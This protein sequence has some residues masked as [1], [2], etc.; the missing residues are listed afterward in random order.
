[1]KRILIALAV[2]ASVQVAGAQNIETAKK[3]LEAALD[4]Y[5]PKTELS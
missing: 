2:L 5:K 1:M 4:A 3:N